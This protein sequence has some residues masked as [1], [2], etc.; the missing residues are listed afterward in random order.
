MRDDILD[1]FLDFVQDENHSILMSSHITTDLEKVADY[2]AFLHN[3]KIIFDKEKDE[4][5][6]VTVSSA[7]APP[8]LKSWIKK[9]F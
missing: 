4:L 6:Y 7:A 3:G 9:T 8:S 5:I 1:V 2:I